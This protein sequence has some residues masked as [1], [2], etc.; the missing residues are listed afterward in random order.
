MIHNK[1]NI[2]FYNNYDDNNNDKYKNDNHYKILGNYNNVMI[3]KS[4]MIITVTVKEVMV[5]IIMIIIII[6]KIMVI[7]MI[8]M[9]M[10][11]QK[12][13]LDLKKNN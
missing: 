4:I 3:L 7:I 2:T 10:L 9:T 11:G 12:A 1:T 5:M 6:V 13:L 8:L